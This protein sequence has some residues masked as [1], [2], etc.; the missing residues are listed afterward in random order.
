MNRVRELREGRDLTQEELALLV[1]RS[2]S[3]LSKI[4]SGRTDLMAA[5]DII[6]LARVL[7]VRTWE[8]FTA[9]KDDNGRVTA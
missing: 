8:L 7:R 2:Q 9:P 5:E 1:G 6:N 3:W 4:E